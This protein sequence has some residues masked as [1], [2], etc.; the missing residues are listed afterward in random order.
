MLDVDQIRRFHQQGFVV[1]ENFISAQQRQRLMARA[2][3]QI[4]SFEPAAKPTLFTTNEQQRASDAYFLGSG[5]KI[6]FFLEEEAIDSEGH[7][8]VPKHRAINKIGHAQHVLDETCAQVLGELPTSNIC[9]QLGME[10]PRAMQAMHI[11]KQPGIGGEVGLHQDST[12]LYTQPLSCIGFWLALEDADRENG[13]LQALPGGHQI[14]LKQ[15][16]HRDGKGSA[17]MTTL[18]D[19]PYPQTN[20]SMLEV[21]AGTLVIL[22]G[23]LPHYSAANTSG[24]S[25]QAFT[26]HYIDAACDYAADNWLQSDLGQ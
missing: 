12:F 7:W 13:C 9:Q 1:I 25:R 22:H 14:P 11:F 5:D 23:Q 15:R 4:E 10:S 17:S 3:Q 24:R 20:L 26:L 2:K 16:F 6:R 18:D 8:Q 21:P 19:S